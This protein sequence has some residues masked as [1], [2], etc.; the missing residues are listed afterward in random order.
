[1]KNPTKITQY[2]PISLSNI[3]SRIASKVL[4]NRLK[5]FLP[6]IISEN[7]SAFMTK[8]LITNNV[9]KAFENMHHISQKKNGKVGEMALKLDMS[10]AYDW[11][12]W[13]CLENIMLKMGFHRQWVDLMVRFFHSVGYSIKFNSKPWGVIHPTKGLHLGDPLLPHLFLSCAESL[14][15]L[16]RQAVECGAIKGIA[17]CA[18]GPA[19]SHLFFV[20]DSLIFGWAINE[21][22]SN[23]IT[24]LETYEQESSQQLNRDKTS[25]FF[26]PNT[27]QPI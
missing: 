7:Q 6:H 16:I 9:L 8:R 5:T 23:L 13:E 2:K 4:A 27:P 17:A 11:V 21:E 15:V 22:C 10:K 25:L 12:E 1:M 19:I 14:S 18:T 26:N 24:I 3:V 20:D